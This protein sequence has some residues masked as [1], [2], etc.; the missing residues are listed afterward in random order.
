MR[1]QLEGELWEKGWK[2]EVSLWDENCVGGRSVEKVG[3]FGCRS[4]NNRGIV[5]SKGWRRDH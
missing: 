3:Y 2:V 4:N 5:A 1:C